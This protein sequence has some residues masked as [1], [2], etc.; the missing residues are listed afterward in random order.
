MPADGTLDVVMSHD[1]GSLDLM[2]TDPD[3]RQW[4]YP[5]HAPVGAGVTY[6]IAVWEYEFPGVEFQLRTSLLPLDRTPPQ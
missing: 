6:E 4:W 3:G 5:I 1:Q 2:L